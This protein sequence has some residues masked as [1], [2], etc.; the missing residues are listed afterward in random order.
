MLSNIL[1]NPAALQEETL[2]YR[3][4]SED[5]N[6]GGLAF[7]KLFGRSCAD[8]LRQMVYWYEVK[9]REKFYKFLSPTNG[10]YYRP[11]DSLVEELCLSESTIKRALKRL[12]EFGILKKWRGPLSFNYYALNM[13]RLEEILA[14][15]GVSINTILPN[16]SKRKIKAPKRYECDVAPDDAQAGPAGAPENTPVSRETTAKQG[17]CGNDTHE[18][19]ANQ[20]DAC[21][22]TPE[23]TGKAPKLPE[24]SGFEDFRAR[25]GN[26]APAKPEA[27]SEQPETLENTEQPE[28]PEN[29]PAGPVTVPDYDREAV[30][31][32]NIKRKEAGQK[33]GWDKSQ[34]VPDVP[35]IGKAK[36]ERK[37]AARVP[38]PVPEYTAHE[39]KQEETDQP[40]QKAT[41]AVSLSER[42]RM[43]FLFEDFCLKYPTRER[44]FRKQ[45]FEAYRNKVKSGFDPEALKKAAYEYTRKVFKGGTKARYVVSIAN[46]FGKGMFTEY[47]PEQDHNTM[48]E[49]SGAGQDNQPEN[50]PAGHE[51]RQSSSDAPDDIANR[52]EMA[53]GKA[54]FRS[55]FQRDGKTLAYLNLECRTLYI[56][57]VNPMIYRGIKHQFADTIE[58]CLNIDV[59][60]VEKR[61]F[62]EM[63]NAAPDIKPKPK[64]KKEKKG[65]GQK[66]KTEDAGE[67][68]DT[69]E[70]QEIVDEG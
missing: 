2:E 50:T 52:V 28:Q 15:I 40:E 65:Q 56:E 48:T 22:S 58:R 54:A 68:V 1:R 43:W 62:R 34:G 12:E 53:I 23:T 39:E 16:I 21:M 66:K 31:A 11:G 61:N 57:P 35:G 6:R 10:P 36:P 9:N 20:G 32:E 44:K 18:T 4:Y 5:L 27:P 25:G 42:D 7:I 49:T 3:K 41:P 14:R 55:W 19:P 8:V 47:L 13:K 24:N 45:D 59:T 51:Q 64:P 33:K 37:A 70:G 29:T 69:G 17:G 67:I 63:R 38:V 46:F 30:Q 60:V 26:L